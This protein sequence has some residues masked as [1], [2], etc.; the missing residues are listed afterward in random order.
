MNDHSKTVGREVLSMA[1]FVCW[2]L[3]LARNELYFQ[4]KDAT[5]QATISRA[6]K[7]FRE[8]KESLQPTSPLVTLE[9]NSLPLAFFCES[10]FTFSWILTMNAK[11]NPVV[12]TTYPERLIQ[13]VVELP[14]VDMFVTTA[15]PVLEPPIITMNTV[16]S[17]LA[18]DYPAHKLACYVSDDGA[19][20]LTFYSLVEASKFAKLRV[21]FCKKYAVQVRAPFMYCPRHL[22]ISHLTSNLNGGRLRSYGRTREIIQMGCPTWYMCPER[23][24]LRTHI[25]SKQ[26]PSMSW[27]DDKLP[28]H[29]EH[30]L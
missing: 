30:R 19:S 7:A 6:K 18:V 29:A 9:R 25:I 24:G 20:P 16:L 26:G 4:G 11:W 3:W 13:W 8:Y 2:T 23:S 5:P 14:P 21:P 22:L 10:W 27:S 12:Y 1:A 15:D 28:F 17:L